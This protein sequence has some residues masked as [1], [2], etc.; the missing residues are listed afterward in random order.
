M[1]SHRG[2]ANSFASCP[3]VRSAAELGNASA[4]LNGPFLQA[5][6]PTGRLEMVNTLAVVNRG[7]SEEVNGKG[8]KKC[9]QDSL[10]K[11]SLKESLPFDWKKKRRRKRYD[12]AGT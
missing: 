9:C 8:R 3:K 11:K 7:S 10:R 4:K 6:S 5:G 12:F 2:A 1:V